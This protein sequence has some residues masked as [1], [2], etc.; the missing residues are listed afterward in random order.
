MDFVD[1]VLMFR[2]S[3]NIDKFNLFYSFENLDGARLHTWVLAASRR[4]AQSLILEVNCWCKPIELLSNLFTSNITVLKLLFNNSVVTPRAKLPNSI[5]TSSRIKDLELKGV[6]FP[7]ANA[8]GELI[9][10]CPVL[11]N[12]CITK[13]QLNNI[14]VFKISTP[15]LESLEC[16]YLYTDR[17]HSC[18]VKTCTP[19]LKRIM[20]K[21]TAYSSLDRVNSMLDY[22]LESLTSLTSAEVSIYSPDAPKKVCSE[23]LMKVLTGV[24]NVESLKLT[25][26]S[27][28]LLADFPESFNKLSDIFSNLKFVELDKPGSCYAQAVLKLLFGNDIQWQ[29]ERGGVFTVGEKKMDG[30]TTF[31]E[32]V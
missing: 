23:W 16:V 22:C 15:L 17:D 4:N 6:S 31:P 11:E 8:D 12:L 30:K 7:N 20:V 1:R 13:C 21:A 3:C 26:R 32:N 9:L 25:D 14:K 29:L 18:R 28:Q 19:N 10:S 5:C 27:L 2:E 24:H